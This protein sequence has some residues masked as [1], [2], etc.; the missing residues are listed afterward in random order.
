MSQLTDLIDTLSERPADSDRSVV[1]LAIDTP[2][3]VNPDLS[4]LGAAIHAA[5]VDLGVDPATQAQHLVYKVDIEAQSEGWRTSD[6]LVPG[7]GE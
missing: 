3:S 7:D 5:L 2:A 4:V 6:Q 1:V